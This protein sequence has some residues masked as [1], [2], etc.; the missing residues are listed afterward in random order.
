[1]SQ[2]EAEQPVSV[3]AIWMV[4]LALLC[5]ATTGIPLL[6]EQ[7]SM[8]A[9]W[10][11]GA[12]NH[13]PSWQGIADLAHMVSWLAGRFWVPVLAVLAVASALTRA[14]KG[15][16]IARVRPLFLAVGVVAG[17]FVS[18]WLVS[19]WEERKLQ[20]AVERGTI[21]LQALEAA[22]KLAS[23]EGDTSYSPGFR[24]SSF[25]SIEREGNGPWRLQATLPSHRCS[26]SY[27]YYSST[28]HPAESSAREI[29]PSWFFECH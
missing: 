22:G 6:V 28:G 17:T 5:V 29:S 11:D 14:A 16:F 24:E 4:V 13:A 23:A 21:A 20:I 25:F 26:N 3:L 10:S 19:A 15:S 9:A 2:E 7:G 27:L 1:M 8:I 18:P 12:P